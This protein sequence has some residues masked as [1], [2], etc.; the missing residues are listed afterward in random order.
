MT[1][2]VSGGFW[3]LCLGLL[4]SAG[5][6]GSTPSRFYQL[7]SLKAE[8]AASAEASPAERIVVAI[9]PLRIPD[10]L[11]RPQIVT[12]SG[13]NE[14]RLAEFDRWAGSLER[15][16]VRVLTEDIS[17]LLPADRFLVI[18][19][20]SASGSALPSLYRVEVTIV[21]F[22]GGPGSS[23]VLKAQ[24]AVFKSGEGLLLHRES[25]IREEVHGPG[26]VDM[27]AAL[28]DALAGLSKDIANTITSL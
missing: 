19:W 26:Y 9:G 6:G 7:G 23:V 12:R 15:D 22:D 17:A 25:V 8:P 10:Y 28:S 18:P 2:I 20:V 13:I 27:V 3:V 11:D 16:T 4:L 24:W 14:I 1:R 21:R 5:C